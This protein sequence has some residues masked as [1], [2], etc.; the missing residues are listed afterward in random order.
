MAKEIERKFIVTSDA[1]RYE[2]DEGTLLL[3][4]YVAAQSSNSVRVRIRGDGQASFTVK[5]GTGLVRDEFEYPVP[6]GDA[7]RMLRGCVGNVIDKSRHLV[8]RGAFVWEVDVYNG[9]LDGL[10]VAEVEL[11]NEDDDPPLPAWA[12]REITDDPAY[13]NASLA[14]KGLPENAA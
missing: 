12:G 11:N 5:M 3:Q 4:G 8:R 1:W 9:A 7:R 6:I 14:L 10:V 2:A 13:S